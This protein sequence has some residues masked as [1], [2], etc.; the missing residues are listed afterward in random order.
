ME[1]FQFFDTQGFPG[2][3][4]FGA[5]F[6]NSNHTEFE[7]MFGTLI[8]PE[9]SDDIC[10]MLMVDTPSELSI[11][12]SPN[13]SRE[14]KGWRYDQFWIDLRMNNQPECEEII[15]GVKL[16]K[17]SMFGRKYVLFY[18]SV[19]AAD[20]VFVAFRKDEKPTDI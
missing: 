5:H 11:Y 18:P 8:N 15:N 3:T 2:V 14:T 7:N 17:K 9:V 10:K 20:P 1:D 16:V 6:F 13:K 19:N 4:F 12:L